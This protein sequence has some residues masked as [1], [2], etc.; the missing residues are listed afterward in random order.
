MN[1]LAEVNPSLP[2]F[3]PISSDDQCSD[4]IPS[5]GYQRKVVETSWLSDQ[6]FLH[7]LQS[8]S[9]FS[10]QTFLHM[11]RTAGFGRFSSMFKNENFF[12]VDA[13]I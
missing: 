1:L 6:E 3:Y 13:Q 7:F 11:N 4:F 9:S 12:E 2:R 10:F 5:I 8:A